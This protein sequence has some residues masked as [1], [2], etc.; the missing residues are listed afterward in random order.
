[1]SFMRAFHAWQ[2][3]NVSVVSARKRW[4]VAKN[5]KTSQ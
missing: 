1:M 5:K 2:L 4:H 3:I